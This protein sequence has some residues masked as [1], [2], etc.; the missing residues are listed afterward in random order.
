[1]A[2]RREIPLPTEEELVGWMPS[3]RFPSD[4]LSVSSCLSLYGAKIGSSVLFL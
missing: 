2:V 3:K 4:H 1:M